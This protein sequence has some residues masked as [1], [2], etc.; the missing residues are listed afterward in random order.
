MIS[1]KNVMANT[2]QARALE[3][4][5]RQSVTPKGD[6][7]YTEVALGLL[8]QSHIFGLVATCHAGAYRGD[9]TIV[10]P[11]FEMN[12]FLQAVQDYKINNLFVVSRPFPEYVESNGRHRELMVIIRSHQS[13]S[14]CFG[15]RTFASS[16]T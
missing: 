4:T 5:W 16:T 6:K 15:R 14:T 9:Q 11:K 13:S 8:P 10:L 2:L 12:S 3:R 1:H 7:F